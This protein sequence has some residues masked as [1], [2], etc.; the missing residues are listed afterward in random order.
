ML[1]RIFLLVVK[2]VGESLRKKSKEVSFFIS[3]NGK[4]WEQNVKLVL[5]LVGFGEC[6][7]RDQ[8]ILEY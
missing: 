5:A 8:T 6:V 3:K 2:V 7:L 1:K 4:L